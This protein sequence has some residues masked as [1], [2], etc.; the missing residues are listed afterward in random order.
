MAA[1]NLTLPCFMAMNDSERNTSLLHFHLWVI[2]IKT[3]IF[4]TS[5]IAIPLNLLAIIVMYQSQFGKLSGTPRRGCA[6]GT[7]CKENSAC[8]CEKSR[9]GRSCCTRYEVRGRTEES[10]GNTGLE[11][12]DRAM[13][14]LK[15]ESNRL[16]PSSDTN[17]GKVGRKIGR[18]E[19]AKK[20]RGDVKSAARRKT[21][22]ATSSADE[23]SIHLM[24]L[25]VSDIFVA[26]S[27]TLSYVYFQFLR[28]TKFV[29]AL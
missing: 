25:A 20:G 11:H 23:S 21:T 29:I 2:G 15:E 3:P 6:S 18:C 17:T 12:G 14:D 16:H 4:I 28:A 27:T 7:G 13:K 1:L 24:V 5:L 8:G 26:S 22:G 19:D 10:N 9:C